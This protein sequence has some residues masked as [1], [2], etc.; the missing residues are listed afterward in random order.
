ML[1]YLR[2]WFNATVTSCPSRQTQKTSKVVD[3]CHLGDAGGAP[4]RTSQKEESQKQPPLTAPH[5]LMQP[6]DDLAAG[7]A[8][9]ASI[10]EHRVATILFARGRCFG[11]RPQRIGR[12]QADCARLKADLARWAWPRT[13]DRR[14]LSKA[15][16][17]LMAP[18][19]RRLS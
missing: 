4:F 5:V 10:L 7:H 13:A 17:E 1:F 2:S 6:V 11:E 8:L 3:P 9:V 19:M 18:S 12:L 14:H 15:K 16:E